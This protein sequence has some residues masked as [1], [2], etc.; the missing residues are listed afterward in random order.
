MDLLKGGKLSIVLTGGHAATTGMAT[1]QEIRK[2]D[3]L[4]G[5]E[6]YWIG[7]KTA[8]EGSNVPTLESKIFPKIGVKFVPIIAGKLQTKFTRHTIPAILKIPVGFLHALVILSEIKPKAV[9]SFGG[10]SSFPIVFWAKIFGIP[11]ILHEQTVAA[12]RATITSSLFATKIALARSESSAYFPKD[13]TIVTGNPLMENILNIK[14]KTKIGDPPILFVFGGSRGSNF[15]NDLVLSIGP[16]VL[17][18]YKIVHITGERDYERVVEVSETYPR[19]LKSNYKIYESV[20]PSEIGKYYEMSDLIIARSGANTVAEILYV[21]RPTIFVPLPR[22]YMNEQYKNAMY[23]KNF[24]IARVLTETEAV[25]ERV[26]KEIKE[27]TKDWKDIVY[28][29]NKKESPDTN[30]A[31]NLVQVLLSNL[32]K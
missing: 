12:G 27:M 20:D 28:S 32:L 15:L 19:E 11:V 13:K 10:Y 2:T 18:D 8:I 1:I 25:K 4:T 31:K 30:A 5:A 22:T 24:G 14:P 3:E 23:A 29:A 7:S 26:I 17:R 21:K 16:E 9:L 6:L